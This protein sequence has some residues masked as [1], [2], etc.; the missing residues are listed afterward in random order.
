MS[1]TITR[2][3]TVEYNGTRYYGKP[4]TVE[5]TRLGEEDHGLFTADIRLAGPGWGQGL[6][7]YVLDKDCAKFIQAVLGVTGCRYWEDVKGTPVI[8]LYMDEGAHGLIVGLAHPI[9]P[10]VLIFKELMA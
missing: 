6:P 8:A 5:A 1:A 10:R 9:E 7:A 3:T 2:S 4:A